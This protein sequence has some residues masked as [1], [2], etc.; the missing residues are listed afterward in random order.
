MTTYKI[1][2]KFIPNKNGYVGMAVE[3]SL[4]YCLEA[5]YTT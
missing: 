5:G 1:P 4:H 3:H 2:K